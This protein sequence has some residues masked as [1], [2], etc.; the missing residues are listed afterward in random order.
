MT[1]SPSSASADGD[2]WQDLRRFTNARIA[3]GRS[4]VSLP[5]ARQLEFQAAHAAARTAVHSAL[6]VPALTSDLSELPLDLH[7]VHSQVGD[8][9]EYLRR[10]DL[11]RRLNA[12]D[13]DRLRALAPAEPADL[14]IVIADGLSALAVQQSAPP[15]LRAFLPYVAQSGLTLAPASIALQG[16]VA[17]GDDIAGCLGARC[18]IVLIGERPGLSAA[19]SLGLYL[20]WAPS[21]E[22][23]DADR[24]CISNIREGGLSFADAAYRAGYL[25][26]EAFRR[27]LSGVMLKDNS[28]ATPEIGATEAAALPDATD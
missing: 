3:L 25:L 2:L 17:I 16:R 11:G 28:V 22:S 1:D 9:S 20:T 23:T 19:D 10:P 15:F 6:D 5:V 27:R 8:R 7:T 14:A 24:N 18:V 21:L 12:A 4:G 13:A 26:Q